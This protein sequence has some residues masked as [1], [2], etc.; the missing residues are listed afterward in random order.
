M[1]E[2]KMEETEDMNERRKAPLLVL[3]SAEK[4]KSAV[5]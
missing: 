4:R 3:T 5:F 1:V 2:V